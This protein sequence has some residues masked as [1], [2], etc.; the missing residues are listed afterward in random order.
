MRDVDAGRV[1]PV[2]VVR[3]LFDLEGLLEE[4]PDPDRAR[5]LVIEL[6]GQR[7]RP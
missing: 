1:L 7:L 2:D 5:R 4:T 3:L 6:L